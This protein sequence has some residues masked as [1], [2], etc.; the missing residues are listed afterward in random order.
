MP[1]S[2]KSRLTGEARED[3]RD[4]LQYT[5]QHW[6]NTQ[7]TKYQDQL[8]STIKLL[9]Q[10]PGIGSPI[11]EISPGARSYPSGSHLIIYRIAPKELL[12]LRIIHSSRDLSR[13]LIPE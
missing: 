4:I 8:F 9:A 5:F 10:N 11:N 12:V 3:I 1:S 13:E 7:K 6:G 2:L